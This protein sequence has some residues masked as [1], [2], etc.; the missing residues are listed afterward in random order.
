LQEFPTDEGSRREARRGRVAR[1]AGSWIAAVVSV[2][3]V[4]LLSPAHCGGE[5]ARLLFDDRARFDLARRVRESAGV[6]IGEAFAF[7]SGLYSLEYAGLTEAPRRGARPAR[8][9]RAR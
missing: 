1:K 3:R 5:R 9:E 4:F 2:T 7:L 8:L 6:P